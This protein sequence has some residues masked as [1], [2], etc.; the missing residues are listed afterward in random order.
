MKMGFIRLVAAFVAVSGVFSLSANDW[1]HWRGPDRNGISIET[2]WKSQWPSAGPAMA[3]KAQAGLGF[4]SVVVTE[5]RAFT[6]G[7]AD[8]KDTVFCFDANTG[9]VL[10]KH[11]YPSELGDKY[12]DGGTT[13]TPTVDGDRV[14]WLGRWGDTFCFNAA[15]GKVIW[16][17]NV[18]IE[19]KARVPDWGFTGAPLVFGDKLILNVGDAGLA[20]DKK[21]GAIVWQSAPKSAGYSTPLP[22]KQGN[23]TFTVFGSAESYVAVNPQNGQEA[24]RIRW[25]T[26]N[27]VNA[28]DPIIDGEQVFVSTGYGKGAALFKL[29]GATPVEVWKSKALRTQMNAAVLHQGH[30]YGVDGDTTEKASLKCIDFAT[31]AEKWKQTGFGSG[32]IIIADGK[33]IALSGTGELMIAPA[34]PDGFKPTS[35]AQVLGGK[36]WTAP[37]LANGRIYCRN[38]RGDIAVIDVRKN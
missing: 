27:G 12:F 23:D 24:W 35:R 21:T 11:S 32:G 18:Q 9:K 31:G 34:T 13:G 10:W 4:S 17:K 20:L 22:F 28:S 33:I 16:N 37:V 8:E 38:S 25:L 7:H 15:D 29:G 6:A 19:T 3:W 30:L 1:P 14:F 5:G 36:C 26:Q 2:G